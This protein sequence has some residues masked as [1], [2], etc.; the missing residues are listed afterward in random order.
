MVPKAGRETWSSCIAIQIMPWPSS[1]VI[2]I[3]S[4]SGTN[5]CS[6]HV[7]SADSADANISAIDCNKTCMKSSHPI[8]LTAL[9]SLSILCTVNPHPL[10]R[11]MNSFRIISITCVSLRVMMCQSLEDSAE[12]KNYFHARSMI[13]LSV[14]QITCCMIKAGT[15]IS[16]QL[17]QTIKARAIVA[18]L[19]CISVQKLRWCA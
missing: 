16:R 2:S 9:A 7:R 17:L 3:V 4:F 10:I 8:S 13:I 6:Q 19:A 18:T 11:F 14:C 1:Y 5:N 12:G 15:K